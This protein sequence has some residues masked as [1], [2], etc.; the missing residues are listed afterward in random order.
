[1]SVAPMPVAVVEGVAPVAAVPYSQTVA[2]GSVSVRCKCIHCDKEGI[3]KIDEDCCGPAPWI[4]CMTICA[5]GWIPCA[6]WCTWWGCQFIPFCVPACRDKIH[7]CEHC[8][9]VVG[10]KPVIGSSKPAQRD[11]HA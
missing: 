9:Q 2:F 11:P 5:L 4:S 1:M 8:D 3:T 6:C 10:K 7:H